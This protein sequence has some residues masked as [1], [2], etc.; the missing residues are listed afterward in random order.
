MLRDSSGSRYRI[1]IH[2]GVESSRICISQA[3]LQAHLCIRERSPPGCV[4][5]WW[6]RFRK[7]S[8]L[9]LFYYRRF[10][11]IFPSSG[12]KSARENFSWD[13]HLQI[14]R[15]LWKF[16]LGLVQIERHLRLS[17]NL[18]QAHEIF[19]LADFLGV[20]NQVE[21]TIDSKP[22]F[23]SS[24]TFQNIKFSV[25]LGL[26]GTALVWA[27]SRER[28]G[29]SFLCWLDSLSLSLFLSLSLSLCIRCMYHTY[30][31]CI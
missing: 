11:L 2:A 13:W 20:T 1:W 19:S 7:S 27:G 4:T 21:S 29:R 9:Y 10:H 6:Q 14:E 5:G 28:P 17:F 18:Y 31:I 8:E 25:G 3:F 16:F 22:I 26:L 30:Y 24:Q 23:S 12:E 15:P